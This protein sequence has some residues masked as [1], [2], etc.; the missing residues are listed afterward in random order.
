MVGILCA[1]LAVFFLDKRKRIPRNDLMYGSAIAIVCG[2]IG[3]KLLAV[4]PNI[5]FIIENRIP[6]VDVVKNGFVFYG[7]VLGGAVGIFIYCRIYRVDILGFLDTV[8]IGLPLG[9]LFGRIGCFCS[10]CCFGRET[11]SFLGVIYTAPADPNTPIGVPLLPT[12]LFESAYCLVIFCVLI[13]LNRRVVRGRNTAFYLIAYSLCRFVNEFFRADA[14]RG[15]LLGIST[16]QII[17]I[18]LV[19]GVLA[20]WLCMKKGYFKKGRG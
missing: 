9:S 15:F 11:S 5:G 6:L 13:Y 1:V 2:L 18:L 19:I 17:S 8:V 4:L 20:V 10:G 3:A 12:Q 16:S 7:G 14:E